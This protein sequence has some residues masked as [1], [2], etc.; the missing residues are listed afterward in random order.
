MVKTNV[1]AMM[2]FFFTAVFRFILLSPLPYMLFLGFHRL[3]INTS[4]NTTSTTM[5]ITAMELA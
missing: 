5:K 2:T 3:C 1:N 4:V